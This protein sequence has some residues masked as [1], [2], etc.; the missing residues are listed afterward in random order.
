MNDT[1]SPID[2][3]FTDNEPLDATKIVSVLKKFIR[4]KRE[5]HEIFFTDEGNKVSII[6]RIL[7]FGLGKKLLKY[8][9]YLETESFSAK[10]ISEELQLKKGTVDGLFNTLRGKSHILGSGSDYVIPNYKIND[11]LEI[12]E[13]K[14]G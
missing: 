11:I 7:I 3:L 8:E 2:E 13:E 10:D 9:K 14:N 1:K 5:T 6:K 4:I 12:L